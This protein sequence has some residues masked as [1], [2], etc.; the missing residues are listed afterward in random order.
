MDNDDG[1]EGEQVIVLY[2]PVLIWDLSDSTKL[3]TRD[4][5]SLSSSQVVRGFL[6]RF[7]YAGFLQC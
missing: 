4:R 6:Q 5:E 2:I 3:R 7:S 1:Y